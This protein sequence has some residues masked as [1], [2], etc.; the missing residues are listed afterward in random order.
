MNHLSDVSR[1]KD[2]GKKMRALS[3]DGAASVVEVALGS[4]HEA[5]YLVALKLGLKEGELAGLKWQTLD[6]ERGLVTVSRSVAM[7][8]AS[9]R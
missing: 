9:S 6:L 2:K 4:R 1:P 3:E 8:Q 7:N 5:M